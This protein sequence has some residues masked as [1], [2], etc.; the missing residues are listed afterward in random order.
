M[1]TSICSPFQLLCKRK[2]IQIL[3]NRSANTSVASFLYKIFDPS[4]IAW[5]WL[6]AV[7]FLK[8]ILR[9]ILQRRSNSSSGL[10]R[11]PP[12]SNISSSLVFKNIE[13]RKIIEH[14]NK[15]FVAL[16]SSRPLLLSWLD[17]IYIGKKIVS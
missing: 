12:G 13:N 15:T 3:Q 9:K 16:L 6:D 7:F 8:E 17:D 1:I 5:E 11:L 14:K 10:W 2:L 4:T